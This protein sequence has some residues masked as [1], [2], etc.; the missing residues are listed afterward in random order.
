ME[1]KN[2]YQSELFSNRLKKK[3]KELRK[4]ARKNRVSCYRIYDRDIPEV[5]VS[6]DLYEFLPENVTSPMESAR[7]LS[8]QNARLSANDYSIEDDIKPYTQ[9]EIEAIKETKK[10][11][12]KKSTKNIEQ[13]SL[14]DEI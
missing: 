12:K 4:W 3:Y 6:L 13:T 7:F 8:D 10:A 11:S 1:N 5:P 9:T 2:Q 14:F